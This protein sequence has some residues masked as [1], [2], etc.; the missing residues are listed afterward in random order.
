MVVE[1]RH[2]SNCGQDSS[3][4]EMMKS[5]ATPL[6][7]IARDLSSAV[8]V[9][10]PSELIATIPKSFPMAQVIEPEIFPRTV[11]YPVEDWQFQWEAMMT[12]QQRGLHAH[13]NSCEIHER[14]NNILTTCGAP[15]R[16]A[17][18]GRKAHLASNT[19]ASQGYARVYW[20]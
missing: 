17:L 18:A 7:S 6:K 5:W 4:T 20:K 16:K 9:V 15:G 1:L 11:K 8:Q 19:K 14:I 12:K 10:T 3:A 2:E 13:Q